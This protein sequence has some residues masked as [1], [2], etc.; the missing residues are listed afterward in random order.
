M[1]LGP[2]YQTSCQFE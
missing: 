1:K 2:G